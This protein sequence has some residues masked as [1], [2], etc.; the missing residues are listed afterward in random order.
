MSKIVCYDAHLNRHSVISGTL[1]RIVRKRDMCRIKEILQKHVGRV[2]QISHVV[3]F[4][5]VNAIL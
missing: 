1:Q 2:W 4:V 3:N 5:L